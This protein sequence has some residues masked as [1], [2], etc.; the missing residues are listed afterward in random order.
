MELFHII[1][2]SDIVMHK[3]LCEQEYF[4][5]ILSEII[6]FPKLVQSVK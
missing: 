3:F 2:C 1:G 5:I 4:N 6:L